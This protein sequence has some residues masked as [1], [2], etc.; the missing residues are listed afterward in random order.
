MSK[1][2]KEVR[3]AKCGTE[4]LDVKVKKCPNCGTNIAK[5]IFKKWWFW[6]IIVLGVLIIGSAMGTGTSTSDVSSDSKKYEKVELQQMID[7]LKEN[8]LKAKN[9]YQGKY[10]EVTGKISN[11]DSDGAYVSIEATNANEWNLDTVLCYIKNDKQLETLM[12]KSVGDNVTIKGKVT[13]VGEVLG[14]SINID[15]VN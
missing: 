1:N 15:E 8:A 12:E 13:S 10:I 9:T 14:Y 4:I 2:K 6:L 5:P 3:C 11:F 7:E